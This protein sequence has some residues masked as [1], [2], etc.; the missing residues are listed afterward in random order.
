MM[1]TN[2]KI[3]FRYITYIF[4]IWINRFQRDVLLIVIDN[5]NL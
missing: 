5:N 2:D 1:Q 4:N 3:I